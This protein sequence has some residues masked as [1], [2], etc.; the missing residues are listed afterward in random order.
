MKGS[1]LEW[2]EIWNVD[3]VIMVLLA[4][5]IKLQNLF[6]DVTVFGE[7]ANAMPA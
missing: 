6:G 3:D 1:W 5:T 2:I 4:T 7:R